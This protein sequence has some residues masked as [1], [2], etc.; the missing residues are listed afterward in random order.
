MRTLFLNLNDFKRH[1]CIIIY[2]AGWEKQNSQN[3]NANSICFFSLCFVP[4][5]AALGFFANYFVFDNLF[6][7]L[8]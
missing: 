2:K 1:Q 7:G 6:M 4:Y 8:E 3:N 5:P